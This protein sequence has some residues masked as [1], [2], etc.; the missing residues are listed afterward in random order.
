MEP[1]T[2]VQILTVALTA[3]LIPLGLFLVAVSRRLA[4]LEAAPVTSRLTA[5]EALAAAHETTLFGS[6][7][8]NGI[9]S[10]VTKLRKERHDLRSLA[11]KHEALLDTHEDRLNR[12]D[13][14]K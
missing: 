12:W 1:S 3:A 13:N 2:W 10:E 11:M 8:N 14:Q 7:G 4:L 6:H 9:N 5:V